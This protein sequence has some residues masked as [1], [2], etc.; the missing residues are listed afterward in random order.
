MITTARVA[1]AVAAFAVVA[2]CPRAASTPAPGERQEKVRVGSHERSCVV[3]VPKGYDGRKVP[4]LIALHGNLGTGEKMRKLTSS[5]FDRLAEKET[6]LVAYPNGVEKSW[7]DGRPVTPA[8]EK[9]VPDVEY[10][11][12]LIDALS[13]RYAVD[14]S[15]VFVTG[16]S[17]GAMFTNRLACELSDR[18]AGFA[19]VA[20]TMPEVT[21]KKCSP[22][23]PVS[24][25]IIHG[26]EDK[27][28]PFRGGPTRKGGGGM[29]LSADQ[30]AAF[31]AEKSGC[32]TGPAERE[33]QD[34]ENDG[35]SVKKVEYG[36]C[37]GGAKVVLYSVK[38]AGH[39]WPG[40]WQYLPA[41]LVGKTSRDFDAA[42]VIW[43]FFKSL[44]PGGSGPS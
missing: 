37:R 24:I 30:T 29:V 10:I 15:R 6:F 38:G 40:G 39:T 42:E 35:T 5:A 19:P 9:K 26:S 8:G 11:S 20:G 23:R 14:T 28:A 3:H 12:K 2:S 31:W 1:A 25:L 22:A 33:L 18:I 16:M 21:E 43:S 27:Y 13:E 32:G 17:N 7:N 4:L 36:G 44:P 41:M 34:A